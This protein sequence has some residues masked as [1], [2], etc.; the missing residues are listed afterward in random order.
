VCFGVHTDVRPKIAILLVIAFVLALAAPVRASWACPDGTVCVRAKN[1]RYTCARDRC[2]VGGSCCKI[3]RIC[4]CKHGDLPSFG[5]SHPTAPALQTPDHCLFKVAAKPN[6]PA[7]AQSAGKLL[8][9]SVDILAA[10]VAVE[11]ALPASTLA[12]QSEYTLG[13]RTP[14]LLS[15]GPSRAPPTA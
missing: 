1:G 3:T 4:E 5:A 10:P 11:L 8:W 12:W 6:L 9:L 2:G 13:Y 15:T 7:L 14:P